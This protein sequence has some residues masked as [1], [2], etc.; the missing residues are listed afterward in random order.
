MDTKD[1]ALL[2]RLLA[3]FKDEAAERLLRISSGLVDLENASSPEAARQ[4]IE[5]I[6]R[7]AHSLK[8]AAGALNLEEIESV[9]Q[10]IESLF[11][12]L[13]RRELAPSPPIFDLLHRATDALARLST[14]PEGERKAAERALVRELLRELEQTASLKQGSGEA[15]PETRSAGGTTGG[16]SA[17]PAPA[18]LPHS[19]ERVDRKANVD[20]RVSAPASETLRISAARLSSILFQAEEMISEKLSLRQR[21][22]D[23]AELKLSLSARSKKRAAIVPSLKKTRLALDQRDHAGPSE[24][25]RTHLLKLVEFVEGSDRIIGNLE[26]RIAALHK[27]TEADLR[28]F[29]SKLDGLMAETKKALMLPLSSLIEIFPKLVRDLAHDQGKRAEFTADGADLEIDR[30]ILEEIKDP[31]IHLV[32]NC[33]DHGI[34][35]AEERVRLGK[36]AAGAISIRIAPKEGDRVEIVVADDGRG[37]DIGRLKAS[38]LKANIISQVQGEGMSDADV[39]KLAFVSGVSTSPIITDISGR[40][41]GLAI[42]SE[43][44]QALGGRI[45]VDTTAGRGTAIRVILPV[46]LATYRGILVR[47]GEHWF[48]VP[49]A[50]ADRVLRL[51]ADQIRTVENRETIQVGGQTL[52]LVGLGDA[53]GIARSLPKPLAQP[54]A[55]IFVLNAGDTRIA[56]LVDEIAGEQEV[57]LKPLGNQ[58]SRVKCISGAMVTGTGKVVPV[59]NP[60]DL[61][62]AALKAQIRS[63]PVAE[64][65]AEIE[66]R[67]KTLLVIE[68]SITARTLLKN[69]LEGAGYEVRTAVD[70]VDGYS[71]LKTEPFDLVVSDVDMP[72]MNGLDLTARIRA[73]KNM[74][75]L[76][77]VLVTA[78]NSPADRERGIDAGA[79]AYIVKSSFDQSNLL[80]VIRR[81]L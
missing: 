38:A 32:R 80:E 28:S 8:G 2:K 11:A 51:G 57:L 29:S 67:K 75:E 30:R 76:P 5:V 31:L 25:L 15:Q 39:V 26:Q 9:C 73:D 70:G 44:V 69:I 45:S 12:A 49:S 34:E 33:I 72:R 55:P 27:R 65:V 20:R 68:D 14:S 10:S 50:S 78:L 48:V 18:E 46:T 23:A 56:F 1:E 41:L 62:K 7:E 60:G 43:K 63:R 66:E 35:K 21:L 22:S 17:A 81:L 36:P 79:N 77:V 61:I 3:T 47:A 71:M 52:P 24:E 53:L 42:V 40:G 16:A 37:I 74:A 19:E 64:G 6:F 58:L 59:L 13:K 54:K 4:T